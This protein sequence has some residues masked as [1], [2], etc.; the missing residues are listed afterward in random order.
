MCFQLKGADL[1][2]KRFP[3]TLFVC[4]VD[5]E[6]W[7]CPGGLVSGWT[8]CWGRIWCR[9]LCSIQIFRLGFGPSH[10]VDLGDVY[11]W[12][13]IEIRLRHRKKGKFDH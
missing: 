11:L 13:L 9:A 7:A 3:S 6:R 8:W 2:T 12:V 4:Q 5:M 1:P 10:T